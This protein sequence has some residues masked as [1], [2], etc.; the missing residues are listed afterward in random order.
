M[1]ACTHTQS[2][3]VTHTQTYTFKATA[4]KEN[5]HQLWIS[6]GSSWSLTL[7][8]MLSREHMRLPKPSADKHTLS[9]AL[10]SL[11]AEG[12]RQLRHTMSSCNMTQRAKF[13]HAEC[14]NNKLMPYIYNYTFSKS[15]LHKKWPTV[16]ASLM[17]I[18]EHW[19]FCHCWPTMT[20]HQDQGH[21]NELEQMPC[22]SL[23]LCKVWMP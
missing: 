21:Q 10:V 8:D 4:K 19:F 6:L 23:P 2:H 11:E 17:L 16:V 15:R 9:K 13:Y 20:L 22:I 18:I 7:F 12:D 1:C 3:T 14:K 5:V